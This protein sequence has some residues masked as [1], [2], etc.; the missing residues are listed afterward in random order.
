MLC[1]SRVVVALTL[2]SLS[3]GA[4]PAAQPPQK[5]ATARDASPSEAPDDPV[6]S[7]R[8]GKVTMR[9]RKEPLAGA[10]AGASID[11][12]MQTLK[13]EVATTRDAHEEGAPP[14]WSPHVVVAGSNARSVA[15]RGSGEHEKLAVWVRRPA[16]AA[17]TPVAI[18]LYARGN[19]GTWLYHVTA[20]DPG[21]K[22][23]D[24]ATLVAFENALRD[25]FGS[26]WNR[27]RSGTFQ[28][29]ARA[30]MKDV[31]D[32]DS[33]PK[34]APK[35]PPKGAAA[36]KRSAPARP[37]ARAAVRPQGTGELSGLMQ[38]STGA[39]AIQEALQHDRPLFLAAA[40]EKRSIDVSMLAPPKVA[41]HPW[42][43]ML[44]SAAAPPREPLAEAVPAEFYYV[45]A[46]RFDVVTLMLDLFDAAGQSALQATEADPFD[47]AL[48][49]RYE[50]SLGIVRG[51]L[52]RA[53][54]DRVVSEL[55]ITGSDPYLR[56]GSDLT[57]I[58]RAKNAALLDA[59]LDAGADAHIAAHG[60]LTRTEV[61]L[62]GTRVKL[63]RSQDG[64]VRQHRATVGDLT[65]V[66][67]SAGALERVLSAAQGKGARLSD[68]PDFRFM[69][70]RDRDNGATDD[71]LAY[72]G[73]RFVA[74]V[75]GPTQKIAEARRQI[76][77]GELMTPGFSA[78]LFGELHGRSP[79]SIDELL[80]A[81]VL[82]RDELSH[83]DGAP[84][85]WRP[86][87]AARSAWG[88]PRDLV[89]LIDLP[90]VTMVTPSEKESYE[91][92]ARGY[93]YD[94][95]TY[96]DPALARL[97][98]KKTS[99]GTEL[100]LDLR[101]L[102]LL[103][104]S[105]YRRFEDETGAAR[106]SSKPLQSGAR[107]SFALGKDSELRRM[108][109]RAKSFLGHS[110]VKLAWIGDFVTVG[111][112]DRA[113]LAKGLMVLSRDAHIPAMPRE[114]RASE[115][116]RINA[117]A[118]LPV[119]VDVD[120][121]STIGATVALTTLRAMVDEAAPGALTWGKAAPYR[122]EVIVKVSA[123]RETVKKELRAD[124]DLTVYYTLVGGGLCVGF[125]EPAIHAAIDARKD[126]GAPVREAG[127]TGA[128]IVLE[129]A[130]E[131]GRAIWSSIAWL[132]EGEL[133]D[134]REHA[135]E[136]VA[137]ALFSGAPEL[138]RDPARAREL[139]FAYFGAAPLTTDGAPYGFGP[140]GL[141]D[142]AR[143]TFFEP[144]WPDVP[145][146]GSP[147]AALMRVV[148]HTRVELAFDDEG[149]DA[150]DKAMKSLH[151]RIRAEVR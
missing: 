74:A 8:T 64:A 12:D 17:G 29:F 99:T 133:L 42:E 69:L 143:G 111:A 85:T 112:V 87:D 52:A 81:H 73:D 116:E 101:Q 53:V 66:S 68:E 104:R 70:A 21:D 32:A 40:R 89:A 142:P 35:A 132:L 61:T 14:L 140:T 37:V 134:N 57:L 97:G 60:A 30:R 19:D 41:P 20:R 118:H 27:G 49:A 91:R 10:I 137:E 76:A 54:G 59:A 151:V 123:D 22:K 88:S 90:K 1:P 128:Q 93:Q 125:T 3:C 62:A 131:P 102:P 120:V 55:A 56:E 36:T 146:A 126:G 63:A 95:G 46:R 79:R 130:S 2:V 141:S 145:V 7:L 127:A 38:T 11:H 129:A 75:I 58:F 5:T 67:N 94:W 122:G 4:P 92:F 71:V 51:P 72:M 39:L 34:P 50:A 16:T 9:E 114:E 84:I 124:A 15:T 110:D 135:S 103:E 48:A 121:T 24:P 148:P 77:L 119:Y 82:T 106:F 115:G 45:R 47:Y 105:G 139:A 31:I 44:K 100:S 138:A 144:A 98:A 43:R 13:I 109:T 33:P 108:L 26:D 86:G 113:A 28:S 147:V 18:D 25:S 150:D 78:L 149:K 96:V 83:T 65:F 6:P 80:L 107:V 23:S 136:A 117:V